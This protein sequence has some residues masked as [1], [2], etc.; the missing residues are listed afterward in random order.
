MD[1][2]T[3]IRQVR[4]AAALG[5]G[6]FLLALTH[7]AY[8]GGNK[9][10][11]AQT[12]ALNAAGMEFEWARLRPLA[13]RQAA[14]GNAAASFDQLMR[15]LPKQKK[16]AALF[17][18]AEIRYASGDYREAAKQFQKAAG[19][20]KKGSFADDAA[21]NAVLALEAQGRD[22]EAF[23]A[24]KKWRQQYGTSPL[25]PEMLLAVTWNA[26]RRD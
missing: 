20:G 3:P 9:S 5:A 14:L 23:K 11:A 12:E 1:R 17:L 16:S 26:L 22:R 18:S 6:L 8:G 13:D 21:F 24:W 19:E 15:D 10:S 2:V 25:L 7:P 4:I